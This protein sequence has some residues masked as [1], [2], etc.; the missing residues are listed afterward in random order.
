LKVVQ[1]GYRADFSGG[2]GHH[3]KTLQVP[4][5]RLSQNRSGDRGLWAQV[6][7]DVAGLVN[8]SMIH[9]YSVMGFGSIAGSSVPGGAT[10]ECFKLPLQ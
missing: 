2:S 7:A 5:R 3:L 8:L 4:R 9:S 1:A 6:H 10:F